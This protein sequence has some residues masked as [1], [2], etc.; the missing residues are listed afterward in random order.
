MVSDTPLALGLSFGWL[1]IVTL[2]Y[3]RLQRTNAALS[4]REVVLAA[5]VA[6]LVPMLILP[7]GAGYDIESFRRVGQ[8]LVE[9][10]EVYSSTLVAGRHPYLPFQ[11]YLIGSSMQLSLAT[12][13]PFVVWLK[14]P[15]VLADIAITD[16]I[17]AAAQRARR[18]P[19]EPSSAALLYALNPVP[20]L[21]SAYHGQFDTLTAFLVVCA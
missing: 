7:I 17:Y 13:I 15:N 1:G 20:M 3:Y 12:G 4:L 16:L 9:G 10:G 11:M 14:L 8:T 6:R 19:L 21:V 18:L 2:L 5:A